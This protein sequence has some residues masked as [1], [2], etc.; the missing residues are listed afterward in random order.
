[1]ELEKYLSG[2]LFRLDIVSDKKEDVIQELV[3]SLCVAKCLQ[4]VD[5]ILD[6]VFVREE[7]RSTGIGNDVA[8]PHARTDLVKTIFLALGR[9][10]TGVPWRSTDAKPVHFIFLVVGPKKASEDYLQV[11]ADISRLMSRASV[12]SALLEAPS[13]AEVLR[14]IGQT[15]PRKTVPGTK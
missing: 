9:S 4:P 10:K 8:I 13:A 6:S 7:D 14:I 15:K 5:V 2:D 11:L 12:R 1:M 3:R